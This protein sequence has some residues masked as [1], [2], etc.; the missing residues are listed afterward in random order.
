MRFFR[1]QVLIDR[2]NSIPESF[3]RLPP[4]KTTPLYITTGQLA[5]ESLCRDFGTED[6]TRRLLNVNVFL[7]GRFSPQKL[8]EDGAGHDLSDILYLFVVLLVPGL[9]E[10]RL[11]LVQD[12]RQMGCRRQRGKCRKKEEGEKER[13]N[14]YTMVVNEAY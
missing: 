6:V 11:V 1:R 2:H 4:S 13:V 7:L 3:Q 9:V 14:C 12:M 8:V 10:S 5:K